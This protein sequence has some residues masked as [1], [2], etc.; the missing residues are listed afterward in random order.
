MNVITQYFIPFRNDK[1]Y[2][3][4]VK[5]EAPTSSDSDISTVM[6]Q[7]STTSFGFKR[8]GNNYPTSYNARWIAIG[9]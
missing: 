3:L 6:Y 1:S 5:A 7:L 8:G 4:T 9:Y 2:A